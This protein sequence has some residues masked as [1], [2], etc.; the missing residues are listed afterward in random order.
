MV[1]AEPKEVIAS[2]LVAVGIQRVIS[3]DDSYSNGSAKIDLDDLMTALLSLGDTERA[4]LTE[5]LG[6]VVTEELVFRR[7]FKEYWDQASDAQ[8]QSFHGQVRSANNTVS[9]ENA[10]VDLAGIEHLPGLFGPFNFREMNL[11]DWRTQSPAI[12]T[13]SLGQKTLILFDEDFKREG[14][15]DTEGLNLIKDALAQTTEDSVVCCLLSHKYHED[16]LHTAWKALCDANGFSQGRVIVIPKELLINK[17]ALFASLV[18]LAAVAPSYEAL[19][20]EI[21]EIVKKSVEVAEKELAELNLIDLDRMVFRASTR[22]GV[23]EPDTLFRIFSVFQTRESRKKALASDALRTQSADLRRISALDTPDD[24]PET[25]AVWEINRLENYEEANV[26]NELH[27]PIDVGDVFQK[28]SKKYILIGP[29]CDL[30]VRAGGWRGTTSDLVKEV[31]LAEVTSRPPALGVGWKVDFFDNGHATFV[32]FK[33]TFSA[34]LACLDLC[35]FNADGTA[36]LSTNSTPP[37]LL[38]P[39]WEKRHGV[40]VDQLRGMI[41]QYN[42]ISP[43]ASQRQDVE[44]L[45]TR[46]DSAGVLGGKIEIGTETLTMNFKRVCRLLPPRSTALVKAYGAFLNR[47]A[48]EHPYGAMEPPVQTVN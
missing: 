5:P 34:K 40:L 6:F 20:N 45:L 48:F 19:R 29:P 23:W 39:T 12:Y 4:S 24:S 3:V 21:R 27:R 9:V 17:P 37:V 14:A 1:S 36:K 15:S 31:I 33:K 35:V 32:D 41:T 10:E 13:E 44:R 28:G 38:I 30:M 11:V 47:D 18:K 8:R 7:R 42:R 22:E 16:T 43:Q 2:V 46:G 25:G 26:L